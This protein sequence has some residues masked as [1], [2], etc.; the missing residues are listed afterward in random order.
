MDAWKPTYP[1]DLD[2]AQWRVVATL[3]P[4][5]KPIGIART[6]PMRG[7]VNAILYRTRSQCSWR[8]LPRDFPHWRTV[9]GYQRQWQLDGTWQKIRDALR[10]STHRHIEA[11]A[12]PNGQYHA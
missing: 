3:I 4:P 8:M 7:V 1:T 5:G 12:S 11:A 9:Y 2:D 10:H 6:T